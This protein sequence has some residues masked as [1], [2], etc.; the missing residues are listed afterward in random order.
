MPLLAGATL[1]QFGIVNG[2]QEV[3]TSL[4][5]GSVNFCSL[6]NCS[7]GTFFNFCAPFVI[8]IDCPGAVG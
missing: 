6:L 8:L 3:A 2:C 5:L 7:G 4:A 1:W